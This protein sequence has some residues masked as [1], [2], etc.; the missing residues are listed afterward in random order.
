MEQYKKTIDAGRI[1]MIYK[2]EWDDSQTYT[3]LDT[4]TYNGESYCARKDS[5]G[6]Y[7]D[8]EE[9]WFKIAS[10]GDNFKLSGVV[11]SKE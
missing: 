5:K 2:G 11:N 6:K 8:N 7:P 3:S 9:Y 10:K 4:V 1:A